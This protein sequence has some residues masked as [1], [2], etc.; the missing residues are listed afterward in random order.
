M[1]HAVGVS[2]MKETIWALCRPFV[3]SRSS[4]RSSLSV[5]WRE[6]K[7]KVSLSDSARK[8]DRYMATDFIRSA[9]LKRV[10]FKLQDLTFSCELLQENQKSKRSW[11]HSNTAVQERSKLVDAYAVL[12]GNR[13]L[14][15]V[16]QRMCH[17]MP[18]S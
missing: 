1:L 18:Q 15:P 16:T 2:E 13:A 4:Q 5:K 7:D 10:V 12:F 11:K 6:A 17:S 9:I 3:T 14:H 8:A